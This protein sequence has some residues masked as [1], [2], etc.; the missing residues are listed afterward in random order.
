VAALLAALAPHRFPLSLVLLVVL[1]FA[2]DVA[3]TLGFQ[4]ALGLG[5]AH[6][7]SFR[8]PLQNAVLIA[9]VLVL[10]SFAGLTGAVGAIP[11]SSF[12]A[13]VL[14][15]IGLRRRLRGARRG[16][17]IPR[18]AL[19]FG[20]LQAASGFFVQVCHRG[21]VVAVLVLGGARGEAGFSAL[22]ARIALAGT[23]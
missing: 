17:A 14:G 8:F 5:A 23:S 7:W 11:L 4:L 19:R 10:H 6:A 20:A 16:V 2:L 13:L 9:A 21:A 18:G 22:A 3:A 1:A 15:S 12:A